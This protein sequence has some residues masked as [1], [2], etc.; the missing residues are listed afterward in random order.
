M[1]FIS[2]SIFNKAPQSSYASEW[3]EWSSRVSS[4]QTTP[5]SSFDA[6]VPLQPLPEQLTEPLMDEAMP[7]RAPKKEKKGVFRRLAG[8]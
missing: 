3:S 4:T 5:G 7:Y 1:K 6:I 8:L 2:R